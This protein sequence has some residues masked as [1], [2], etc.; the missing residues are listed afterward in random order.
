MKFKAN[1]FAEKET[2]LSGE[3]RAL[4]E[5]IVRNLESHAVID[6]PPS[7]RIGIEG[8]VVHLSGR[9]VMQA[10]KQMVEEIV[11]FTAG[12]VAVDN[13]IEIAPCAGRRGTG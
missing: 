13:R 9:V 7:I 8:G 4:R 3:A 5:R 1:T 10:E 12:V 2:S 11:R 6:L